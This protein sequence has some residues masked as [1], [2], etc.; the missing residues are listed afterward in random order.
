LFDDTEDH[1]LRPGVVFTGQASDARDYCPPALERYYARP[2]RVILFGFRVPDS[3][4]VAGM[5]F[6][7][8]PLR[9]VHGSFFSSAVSIDAHEASPLHRNI[10][11]A[12]S[13]DVC[14]LEQAVRPPSR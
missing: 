1:A 6:Y 8:K 10:T 11:Q 14:R 4:L 5:T 12:T 7:P 9:P 3:A 13:I 2:R